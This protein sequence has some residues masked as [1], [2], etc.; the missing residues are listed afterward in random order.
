MAIKK[1]DDA[2]SLDVRNEDSKFISSKNI[3]TW[4]NSKYDTAGQG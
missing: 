4:K 3:C 1:S 2:V